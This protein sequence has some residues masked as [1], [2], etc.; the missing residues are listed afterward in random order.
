[1]FVDKQIGDE[2]EKKNDYDNFD[3]LSFFVFGMW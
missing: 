3:R 1:M 2:N